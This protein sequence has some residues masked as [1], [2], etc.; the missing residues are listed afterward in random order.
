VDNTLRIARAYGRLV[1]RAEGDPGT[2]SLAWIGDHE[3]RMHVSSRPCSIVKEPLF[4]LYLFDHGAKKSSMHAPA[5]TLRT[6]LQ[7]STPWYR[8]DGGSFVMQFD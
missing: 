6:A 7:R 5:I 2:T 4:I 8:A 1:S 3:I